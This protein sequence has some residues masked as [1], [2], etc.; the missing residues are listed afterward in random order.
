MGGGRGVGLLQSGCL[1]VVVGCP[2]HTQTRP[3]PISKKHLLPSAGMNVLRTGRNHERLR[4]VPQKYLCKS[5]N[6]LNTSQRGEADIA[7][8]FTPFP[9]KRIAR[10]ETF[11]IKNLYI[12]YIFYIFVQYIQNIQYLNMGRAISTTIKRKNIDLP[13]ETFQKLSLLAVSQGKSLKAYIEGL[14]ITKANSVTIDIKP[15]PSPSGDEWFD[16]AENMASV[17]KGISE[18][19]AGKGKAFTLEEI[20]GA[21]GV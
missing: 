21:L 9:I 17:E 15:N 14:L 7:T 20:K 2:Q 1:H 5:T 6:C 12:M 4:I 8:G 3:Q 13:L 16:V 11:W 19:K 10:E 18:M